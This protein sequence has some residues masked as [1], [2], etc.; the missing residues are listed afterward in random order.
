MGLNKK[1]VRTL[2]NTSLTL[3]TYPFEALALLF[4]GRTGSAT[5]INIHLHFTAFKSLC[6]F[7]RVQTTRKLLERFH[8]HRVS[9][10]EGSE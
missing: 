10:K 3:I 2:W 6:A 1:Q 5:E 7:S 8:Y 4:V 9:S